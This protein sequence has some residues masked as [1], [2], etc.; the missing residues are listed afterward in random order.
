MSTSNTTNSLLTIPSHLPHKLT[1]SLWDF[2]WYT[3]TAEGEPYAD[4]GARF[5]ELV[6]RGYNTIRICAMPMFLFTE[7][8]KREGTLTF[9]NLAPIGRGTRWYNCKGG[10]TLDGHAHILELFR[11]AKEHGCYIILSSWEYQQSATFLADSAIADE[12]KAIA[13]KQRFMALAKAM[14]Q[15]IDFLKEHGYAEQ[16]AYAELH[17]EVEYG[18]L[19]DVATDEGV[20]FAD[21]ASIIEHMKPYIEEAV[22]YMRDKHD[23]ILMTACYTTDGNYSKYDTAQNLQ[24]GHYH[25]YLNGVLQELMDVT[26]IRNDTT[27]F[28]NETVNA[29]LRED[30]PS[31]EEYRLPPD[32]EWKLQGNPVGLRLFYLHDWTDPD[33]WDYFLYERYANHRIS[34]LQKTNMRYEE[35]YRYSKAKSLPIVIGEGY[36]G[37]TPL[38]TGF[39]EGPVGKYIA[40]YA[41][42]LGLQ[43]GFWGMVLCS[44]CAPHHPF[45]HDVTWQQRMNKKILS[46]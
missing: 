41:I 44:N 22:S 8:G 40:E 6:E 27:P 15:L 36:V 1:I 21:S 20:A 32:K 39:E 9:S 26:G 4:L 34:M 18:S 13:P 35:L 5:Q 19:A 25:L 16:I 31:F 11:Q 43:Y 38:H 23:D 33:K 37:Y 14:S 24:V 29:L 42:Q 46:S 12:L 17:N 3:M 30:A 45:W 28:P 7:H 2:S 10:E